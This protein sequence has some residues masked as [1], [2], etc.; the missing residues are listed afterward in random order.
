MSVQVGRI[1]RH[2]SSGR[3][4]AVRGA[5]E[6]GVHLRNVLTGV[7]S[8]PRWGTFQDSYELV[9]EVEPVQEEMFAAPVVAAPTPTEPEAQPPGFFLVLGGIADRGT[10]A[11]AR[12][13]LNN[14]MLTGTSCP[15]CEQ[16]VMLYRRRI[17]L[18][19]VRFVVWLL[20]SHDTGVEWANVRDCPVRG[21]DYGK[22][23]HWGLTELKPNDDDPKKRTSGLWRLTERGRRFAEN[24]VELPTHRYVYNDRCYGSSETTTNITDALK[25]GGFD[26]QELMDA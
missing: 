12:D 24:A 22:I 15:C 17:P 9:P 23:K 20:K 10:I 25:T 7:N 4:C 21:G 3:L 16:R 1:Y 26:Y 8:S 14:E 6:F 18:V 2:K 13:V 19:A 5:S 11:D